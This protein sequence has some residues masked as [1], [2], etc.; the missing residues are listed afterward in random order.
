MNSTKAN[1]QEIHN[2]NLQ[3]AARTKVAVEMFNAGLTNGEI[4][5]A[6]SVSPATITCDLTRAGIDLHAARQKNH[7]ADAERVLSLAL[8]GYHAMEIVDKTG[9]S[10]SKVDKIAKEYRITF[11]RAN[12]R[13]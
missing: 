7:R 3:R 8:S 11:K 6:L 5:T 2:R 10:R 12:A 13:V 9:F 4:A 1:A